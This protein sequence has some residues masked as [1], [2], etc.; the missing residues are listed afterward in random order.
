MA[1]L[2]R[3]VMNVINMPLQIQIVANLML[4]KSPLPNRRFLAQHFRFAQCRVMLDQMPALFAYSTLDNR[5]T[6]G[7]ICIALRQSPDA[8]QMFRQQHPC[9]DCKRQAGTRR[10]DTVAQ[11]IAEGF[12]GKKL[13]T[14]KSIYRKEIRSARYIGATIFGHQS[15]LQDP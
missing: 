1:M 10:F 5:P 7:K 9:H 15:S 14:P 8:M 6:P 2:D 4:P 12:M 11:G 13:A 3:V